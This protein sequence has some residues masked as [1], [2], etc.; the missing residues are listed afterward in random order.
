VH[1]VGFVQADELCRFLGIS[2]VFVFH[3]LHDPFGAVV[4]EAMAAEL[5]VI[6]SIY[7]AATQDLVENDVTGYSIDP[8]D[9]ESAAATVLKV[10][11][12][13]QDKRSILVKAAFD[14]V[15][16][17]DFSHAADEM[18]DFTRRIQAAS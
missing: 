18:M 4:S 15:Q 6:S 17:H 2:D 16:Q 1:F 3:T 13:P 7:A 5:P 10:L 14:R 12:M 9:T 8:R 11:E